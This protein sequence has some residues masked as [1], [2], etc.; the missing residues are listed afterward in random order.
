[1]SQEAEVGV[2]CSWK[3]GWRSNHFFTSGVLWGGVVVAD[4][5]QV[6]LG[7]HRVVNGF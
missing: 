2:K 5:M 4:E 7:W 6:Q 1:L 3:R